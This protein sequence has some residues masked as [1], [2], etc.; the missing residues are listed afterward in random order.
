MTKSNSNNKSSS[1]GEND[2]DNDSKRRYGMKH[3]VIQALLSVWRRKDKNTSVVTVYHLEK[4][5][6]N[7]R[8]TLVCVFK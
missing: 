2:D 5:P 6:A 4:N 7:H 1:I 3:T 8:V